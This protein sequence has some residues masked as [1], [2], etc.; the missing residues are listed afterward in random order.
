MRIISWNVLI[1]GGPRIRSIVDCLLQRQPDV[2]VLQETLAGRE[3]ELC[4]RLRDAGF[5]HHATAAREAGQRGLCV[6]SRHTFE[7]LDSPSHASLHTRGWLEL[8][9]PHA[10]IDVGAVYAPAT[11]PMLPA[12]WSAA[13]AWWPACVDRPYLLIGDFN[14]GESHVDSN[15]RF[16]ADAGMV[17]LRNSGL[18]D[19]WRL[20]HGDKREFT[21]RVTNKGKTFPFRLDHAFVSPALAS[22]VTACAYD[23]TVR[24]A[25][26]SDCSMLLL[27]I[28]I[29][30][31]SSNAPRWKS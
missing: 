18:I 6:L 11:A 4:G 20:L 19:A 9:L 17:A 31:A 23:H 3:D 12:F 5:S 22:Q 14:A 28:D 30:S 1:G 8:R 24:E 26:L 15:H 21:W 29:A 25:K 16:Q 2:I 13:E 10:G 27:D 7:V